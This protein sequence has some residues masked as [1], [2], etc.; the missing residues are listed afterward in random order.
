[1][2]DSKA[3]TINLQLHRAPLTAEEFESVV[4]QAD[5]GGVKYTLTPNPESSSYTLKLM[6]TEGI[7]EGKYPIKVI[8]RYTDHIGR[9]TA[10]EA[11]TSITLSNTPFNQCTHRVVFLLKVAL[12]Q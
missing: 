3:I 7:E 6:S 1:L 12:K 10:T 8:A 9:E 11:D 4:L 5:C 2:E